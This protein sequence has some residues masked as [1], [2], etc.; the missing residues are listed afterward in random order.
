MTDTTADRDYRD[1]LFLPKTEFPM[2]AGLPKAEPEWIRRWDALGLYEKLRADAKSRSAAP[3]ILHDGPPYANGHIHLGTALNKIIKDIIVRS[4]QMQGFDASYLPGWDCHGLPIEWKVEEEFR[5]KNR[6]KDS[7]PPEE[8]RAACRVYAEHWVGVQKAEFRS[9]GIEGEWND[10]YLTMAFESEAMIV[11]EFLD[12]AMKGGLVRGAKPIMWSPVERTALAE[13]EV[14]YHDRKVPVVWVKFPVDFPPA[15][16]RGPGGPDVVAALVEKYANTSVVIWTTTPWTIPANQAVSFNPEV[17]YGLYEVT[18]VATE[19]ELGFAPYVKAGDKLIFADKLAEDALLAAKAKAWSRVEDINPADLP[20]IRHPLSGFDEFFRHAIPLLAG[21]HVTDD[22]GTGFVHTA[23][24]HG[25]DDF[26][27]WVANGHTTQDIRQ[28]V[29]AD[30]KY[31]DEVPAP[32]AGLEIIVTSGKKRGEAG[33]ANQEVIRLLAESGNLLA[34]GITTIRDAHSWRSKAPVIRRATPQWFIAMDKPVHNGK[35]LRELAVKAIADTEFFPATG[36]NRLSA[37]VESRPDWLISRQR[38]WGVPITLFV[39]AAGQP[40]TAALSKDEAAK[41]NANIKAAIE[42]T[43]V[44]GW[45]ATPLEAFFEGTGVS[46]EGW[47]KVTDVLDVW[48]DSGTTHAFALRKR[49]IIDNATGQADV[50]M[51]GSD[52]HRGWFQSSLLES[53][54]TRGMAPYKK[55]V[56]H[57]MVVDAD[58]KKMSKSIGNTIE[59]DAFQKQHG[60]EILRIWTASADYWDD[61]RISDEI[62]KGTVET[63][64]KL[65]NTLRYLLGAL[66]GYTEEEALPAGDMPS[67]E[68][69]ML[70]RLSELDRGVRAAYASFDFKRAMTQIVNFVNVELSA[71]YFDV[72]KDAL[73]CDPAFTPGAAWDDATAEWGNR[74]RAVRTVMALVMERL[75]AW[76]AP[77]MPFTTDEAFGESHLKARA[78]SVH[79]LQFPE[80]PEG[81]LNPQ[82]AARWEKIFAVR[83]VVTGALEVERREK[84]IGASLEAAPKVI[85]ADK[86]LI[87]AFEGENAGDI[88]ITSGAELTQAGEGPAGAFTLAEAPGIWVVPQKAAGIK[89]RRSWKYF[90]PATADPSFP[91]ITPRDALAVRASDKAAG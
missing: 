86:A 59:P 68:R 31:T 47:E 83:R 80:T 71:V 81:W 35:T 39:N 12:M 64:R 60:I 62:I 88:F 32:L 41:L 6:P 28:I 24:A 85:I 65:R 23:P 58:G 46:P 11:S 74:R 40:H 7:V 26:E 8:F 15:Y 20:A 16:T 84:R 66:D 1:T 17:S 61:T 87:D 34:R 89:C 67:L 69:F 42:K 43:G 91:D 55:V 36:R 45:F 19:E 30:G 49:G 37:M 63:Y 38:N 18:N 48:F 75:L 27:V 78:P 52:Q 3:F 2:R 79:L 90:D 21:S 70:H 4:H 73:Y 5:S 57:G 56:T 51:E 22:A 14:E 10:P 44:D 9:L 33:K 29:D 50:Y 54:A 53:C 25:E 82:L 76:L 13:A 77:V 72:R